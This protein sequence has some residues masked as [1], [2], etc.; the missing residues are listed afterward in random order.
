ML[1]RKHCHHVV[2][3]FVVYVCVS[4]KERIRHS[5]Y[6]MPIQFIANSAYNKHAFVYTQTHTPF[7]LF[8]LMPKHFYV[9]C[10]HSACAYLCT[11]HTQHTHT[12]YEIP[13]FSTSPHISNNI[14]LIMQARHIQ[15]III[16][17]LPLQYANRTNAHHTMLN[18]IAATL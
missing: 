8:M 15:T 11:H 3:M 14:K 17:R 9:S 1:L 18:R 16:L 5:C 13:S 4:Y 6:V 7:S 2:Y 12:L 10:I